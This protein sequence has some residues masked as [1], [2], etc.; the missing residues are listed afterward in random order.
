M[1]DHFHQQLGIIREQI[2]QAA[3][4]AGRNTDEILL[5][6]VTKK[7]S[8]EMIQ[9][10]WASGL[11]EFGENKVQELKAKAPLLPSA[12]SWHM[13][14]HLQSNKA[15][16]AVQFASLIHSVDS[17]PLAAEIQKQAGKQSKIQK[18]LIEVNVAG[19]ASKFGVKPDALEALAV[20]VNSLTHLELHGLMCM[21]PHSD[22]P[23]KARPHFAR[24]R[25]LRDGLESSLGYKLPVLSMGM[26]GDFVPAIEEGAT[27]VR[28]GTALFG[29]RAK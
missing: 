4:R 29:R 24:L 27:I 8:L 25:N 20:E 11:R 6:G 15:R 18:I 21:A 14:G 7:V 5:L 13:I 22:D 3:A 1:S 10:A 9:E 23:E 26:S 28:I 2:A 19:E 12:V 17:A 16:D